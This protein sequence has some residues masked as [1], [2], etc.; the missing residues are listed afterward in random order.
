M[1]NQKL[2]NLQGPTHD[3][4]MNDTEEIKFS[5]RNRLYIGNLT[6]DVTEEELAE[7]FKPFGEISEAFT[8]KD[9]NF[10]FLKVVSISLINFISVN[11][12]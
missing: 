7:L 1:I 5:G 3:L 6:N 2:K 4:Q 8:N 10:A 12:F 9:K 11:K